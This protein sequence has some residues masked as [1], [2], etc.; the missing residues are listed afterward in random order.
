MSTSSLRTT[1]WGDG[2]GVLVFFHGLLP[3]ASGR[4]IETTATL[5]AGELP[6]RVVAVDAPGFGRS[7]PWDDAAYEMDVLAGRFGDLARQVAGRAFVVAGHSWG[8][9]LA[10][11]VAAAAPEGVRGLVLL[12]GGHFDH[13]DLPDADPTQTVDETAEEM[14]Q[15]GWHTGMHGSTTDPR[16]AAAAMNALMR[17]RSSLSYAAIALSK[18]PVLLLTATEPEQRR[19]DNELRTARLAAAVPDLA[20]HAIVGSGHEVLRDAPGRVAE[21]VAAWWRQR[22]S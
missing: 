18:I 20:A 13:A 8:A 3:T 21:L 4:D 22:L 19:L 1:I 9:A 6:V 17:S 12:D 11:R 15:I 5:L 14:E 16:A 10:V 7:A 2:P